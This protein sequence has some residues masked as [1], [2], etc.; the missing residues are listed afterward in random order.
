MAGKKSS[1]K[2]HLLNEFSEL[3]NYDTKF[4]GN[5]ISKCKLLTIIKN[6]KGSFNIES[7]LLLYCKDSCLILDDADQIQGQ[8][9]NTLFTHLQNKKIENG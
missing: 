9:L 5:Q 8:N 6:H 2:T 4:T 1:G 7:G 3:F